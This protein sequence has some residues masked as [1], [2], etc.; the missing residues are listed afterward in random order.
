MLSAKSGIECPI[1]VE[2]G[3]LHTAM[4]PTVGVAGQAVG[5]QEHSSIKSSSILATLVADSL[6]IIIRASV[7]RDTSVHFT[8]T[9]DAKATTRVACTFVL[10]SRRTKYPTTYDQRTHPPTGVTHA[11]EC[12]RHRH[13][14]FRASS[15]TKGKE[16]KDKKSASFGSIRRTPS[17]SEH[18]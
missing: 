18:L 15:K 17:M 10:K 14:Q 3:D 9:P 7:G 12:R 16:R 8:E 5:K 13:A 1:R 6:T 2:V 4:T 11:F